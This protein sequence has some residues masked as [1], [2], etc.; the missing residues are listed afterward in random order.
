[1]VKAPMLSH[2]EIDLIVAALEE[3]HDNHPD[4]TDLELANDL[5]M[6]KAGVL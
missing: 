3:Y 6:V 1:M 4:T 2:E 5:K